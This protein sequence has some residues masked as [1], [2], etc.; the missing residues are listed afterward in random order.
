MDFIFIVIGMAF[1][2]LDPMDWFSRFG[3]KWLFLFLYFFSSTLFLSINYGVY[4]LVNSTLILFI[5]ASFVVLSLVENSFIY[6]FAI[7]FLCF[8]ILLY[9]FI[10]VG[11]GEFFASIFFLLFATWLVRNALHEKNNR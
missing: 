10:D 6:K 11:V 9:S 2:I 8:S 4:V 1:L 5:L 7:L 3:K